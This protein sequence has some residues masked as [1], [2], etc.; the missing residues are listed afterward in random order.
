MLLTTMIEN[1][2]WNL[3]TKQYLRSQPLSRNALVAN[4]K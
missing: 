4:K 1:Q 3:L 2:I